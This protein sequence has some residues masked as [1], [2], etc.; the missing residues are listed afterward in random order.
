[1]LSLC[2]T[3]R[4]SSDRLCIRFEGNEK[5]REGGFCA[6]ADR[7]SI[8]LLDL[9]L[10]TCPYFIFAMGTNNSILAHMTTEIV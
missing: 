2:S 6:S 8:D 9:A 4:P 7:R 1:M 5:D 10:S 3:R